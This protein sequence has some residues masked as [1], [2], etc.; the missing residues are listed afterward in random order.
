MVDIS[1]K[2]LGS[3]SHAQDWNLDLQFY[4][5]LQIYIVTICICFNT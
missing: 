3:F 2:L 5:Y 1:L 4:L